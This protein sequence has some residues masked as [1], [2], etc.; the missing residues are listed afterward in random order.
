MQNSCLHPRS[1]VGLA[2]CPAQSKQVIRQSFATSPVSSSAS[3]GRGLLRG[4]TLP[5]PAQSLQPWQLLCP[6]AAQNA[7][8]K[9]GL[10]QARK[11]S[12]GL[13]ERNK[14]KRLPSGLTGNPQKPQHARSRSAGSN[15]ECGDSSHP[16]QLT[17]RPRSFHGA[18]RGFWALSSMQQLPSSGVLVPNVLKCVSNVKA[19]GPRA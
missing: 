9:F 5:V 13:N 18:N 14:C 15:P 3:T 8:D 16:M 11:A 1:E 2:S 6:R 10:L 19:V 17:S 12:L 4:P 7:V